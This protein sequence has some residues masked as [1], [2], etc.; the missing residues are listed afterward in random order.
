LRELT[1]RLHSATEEESRRI[2]RLVHDELGQQLT[3]LKMDLRAIEKLLATAQADPCPKALRRTREATALVDDAVQTVQK[4]SEDLRPVVLDQLGLWS[5]LREEV[6]RFTKRS[7]LRCSLELPDP[8]PNMSEALSTAIYRIV[9]ESLTNI[10]RHAHATDAGVAISLEG[11]DLIVRVNDNGVG[12]DPQQLQHPG[13]LGLIGMRER[14][15]QLGGEIS[16]FPVPQ[17]GTTV[18]A[19]FPLHLNLQ[20]EGGR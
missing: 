2:G 9:R 3:G 20:P 10:F 8:E 18:R 4:I 15:L 11:S 7:E 16:L 1:R 17:G 13:S 5:A 19:V 6:R 14:A 12:I